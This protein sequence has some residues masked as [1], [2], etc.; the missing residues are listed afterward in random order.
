MN[1]LSSAEVPK[2]IKPNLFTCLS[3]IIWELSP[4]IINS[5]NE[6]LELTISAMGSCDLTSTMDEEESEWTNLLA[7]SVVDVLDAF[8]EISNVQED[9]LSFY[10]PNIT[11]FVNNLSNWQYLSPEL[12]H[13]V[14]M[15]IRDFCTSMPSQQDVG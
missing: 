5:A 1:A 9:F 6:I 3:D 15:M 11:G 8:T 2:N 13:N 7:I 12:T 4:Y 14:L 10:I